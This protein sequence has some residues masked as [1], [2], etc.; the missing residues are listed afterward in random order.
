MLIRLDISD[1]LLFEQQNFFILYFNVE[2]QSSV[3]V[4][5]IFISF[6]LI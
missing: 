2:F 6:S 1:T 5:A 4:Y 3:L